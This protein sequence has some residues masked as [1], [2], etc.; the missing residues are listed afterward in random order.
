MEFSEEEIS[1]YWREQF[2]SGWFW[3]LHCERTFNLERHR[4]EHKPRNE[5][6]CGALMTLDG[7]D[8]N[9][10][11]GDNSGLP[12]IPE[13]GGRYHEARTTGIKFV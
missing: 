13:H 9:S 2:P 10:L 7:F 5:C 8:W 11:R 12:E 3:C 1:E 4:K 6:V